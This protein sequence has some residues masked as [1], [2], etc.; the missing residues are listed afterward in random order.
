MAKI[1]NKT[2]EFLNK[3]VETRINTDYGSYTRFL[4]S[5]PIFVTYYKQ[6]IME[7]TVD[8]GFG[9]VYGNSSAYSSAKKYNKISKV[10]LY[11]VDKSTF[12][13]DIVDNRLKG[14]S[15]SKGILVPNILEPVPEDYIV[16]HY[17]GKDFV[18]KV[19]GFNID[20]IK[21]NHFYEIQFKFSSHKTDNLE[22]NTVERFTCIYDKI[23]TEDKCVIRDDLVDKIERLTSL[24]DNI[25][26]KYMDE[27]F[28][29]RADSFIFILDEEHKL[30]DPYLTKFISDNKLFEKDF[31]SKSY[32]IE[33]KTN[34]MRGFNRKYKKS[35]YNYIE[36]K[37][38][39]NKYEN[40]FRAIRIYDISTYFG[41]TSLNYCQIDLYDIDDSIDLFQY[42]YFNYINIKE[43]LPVCVESEPL[44]NDNVL[45]NFDDLIR[46]HLNNG[47]YITM[48]DFITENFDDLII[49]YNFR[50]FTTTPIIL[51]I[52]KHVL[53]NIKI[54]N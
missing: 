29:S 34:P 51:Y 42:N 1:L 23:G 39:V 22:A 44:I 25:C 31:S 48:I 33:E 2:P 11:D 41:N 38:I 50:Y 36:K 19:T 49:E 18:F 30:Y 7:T 40:S 24:Y 10:P 26:E 13:I 3:V 21:S 4:E 46:L 14:E 28:N 15:N 8:S 32:L 5:A 17:M 37:Q 27:F 43:E 16:I 47:L 9:N 54:S 53:D 6:N 35:I 52:I 45:D 20:G 12:D